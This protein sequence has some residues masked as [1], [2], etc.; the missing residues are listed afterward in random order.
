MI[1]ADDNADM[2]D[3]LSHL[4]HNEYRVH[5]VSDG[6]KAIEATR[7]L[8]PALLLTDVMM[9]GLDG[10]GVLRAVRSDPSLSSIPV[11]LLS[12]RAGEESRVEGLQA[13]ADDYLVKPFTAR[14]LMARVATHV[15][16]A[17][18]RREG[19][20]REAQLRAEAEL[21]R[22]RLQELLAQAPAGI[23]LLSGPEH[24]W[25]FVNEHYVRMA[26]RN[27]IAE[28]VGKTLLES[29]PELANQGF[30]EL[31]DE[32]Y[33]T[34]QPLMGRETKMGLKKTANGQLEDA[35]FDFVYQPVRNAEQ[36]VEG[37]LVHAV[38][39]TDRRRNDESRYRL[40]AIVNSADDAIVSKDLNGI[41][42]S[43]NEGAFR[44]FGY[45]AEEMVGQSILRVIP[46]DRRHE[47]DE[48]LSKLRAGQRIEHYETVRVRKNGEAID[49][50]VTISPIR[51]EAGKII[52]ASKV[53]RDISD[54]K[55]VARLL[56]QSEKLAATGRM[57]AS[58]AHEINNPL[59]SLVNLI[60]L[61]RHS[62]D[63]QEKAHDY[64][65]TAERELERISHIARQTLGYYRDTSSPTELYLHD[66]IKNVLTVYKS[67]LL[68]AG[69]LL[70]TQFDDLQKVLVSKGRDAADSFQ[71]HCECC[72]CHASRRGPRGRDAA[73]ERARGRRNSDCYSRQRNRNS[74]GTSSPDF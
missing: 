19:A 57:A 7:E 42:S 45:T 22:H 59:E 67:K 33:R 34:G 66:L 71:H 46:K 5:A 60:F 12:A 3:Y 35:Y 50:S 37:I 32:V 23:G 9:P 44:M 4:L 54:R 68:S 47:E 69:I 17:N 16:M 25:T 63:P 10:F 58:I 30:P 27:S 39:V 28:F 6:L 51:N 53:A 11:I 1:V 2:R 56:L 40:A 38:D 31:L 8:R 14:E 26:G 62:T 41:V 24:R 74:R 49:I 52:G 73:G 18:L 36:E 29:L 43:W 15:K 65:L 64:L 72:R 48:I 70:D 21:Q 13:G 20:E 61:A 55:R